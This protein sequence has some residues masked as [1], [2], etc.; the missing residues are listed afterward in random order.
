MNNCYLTYG[1]ALCGV[2]AGMWTEEQFEAAKKNPDGHIK[3][4]FFLI[5]QNQNDE[6]R[7]GQRAGNTGV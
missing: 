5:K 7:V 6:N 4:H 3:H 1:Q 2:A